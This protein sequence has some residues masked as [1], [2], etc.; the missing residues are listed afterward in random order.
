[1]PPPERDT[2]EREPGAEARQ[3]SQVLR[4]EANGQF[5]RAAAAWSQIQRA[6]LNSDRWAGEDWRDPPQ[7]EGLDDRLAAL[8]AWRGPRDTVA[9]RTYLRARDLVNADQGAKARR[10]LSRLIREPFRARADYLRASLRF[11]EDPLAGAVAFRAFLQR[12]PRDPLGLYMLG[13]CFFTAIRTDES[14]PQA[15]P[16]ASALGSRAIRPVSGVKTAKPR[17]LPSGLRDRYLRQARTAYEACAALDPHGPLAEDSRGKAAGC[18]FRQGNPVEALVRYCAQLASLPPE[19]ENHYAFL[20]ARQCLKRM[21]LADHRVFQARTLARPEVASIYLDLHLDYGRS[22]ARA[23]YNL[24][25]FALTVLRRRPAAP[26]SGRLLA[27]LALIEDRL[28]RWQSGERLASAAI[29]RCGPGVYRDQAAWQLALSL[30]HLGRPRDALAQYEHLAAVA[31]AANLRR[32]AHEAAAILSEEKGDL[33]N[34]IRHYF[35]LEYGADYGYLVDCVASLDELR[36]FLRRFPQHPRAKLVRYSI[37]FRQL[38][39]AQYDAAVRTFASLGPWLETAE[40]VYDCR[41]VKGK[42]RWPPLRLARFLAGS[43][44]S[45]AAAKR[46]PQKARI[47]YCRGQVLFQQRYLAFYNGVLWRGGREY[48]LDIEGPNS[49]YSDL[50]SNDKNG[51]MAP[52][53]PDQQRVFDRYEAEHTPLYQAAQIFEKIARVYPRTPEAPKALYSAAVCYTLPSH[54]DRFLAAQGIDTTSRAIALYRRLQREYPHD[55]LADAAARYG[56]PLP[57]PAVRKRTAARRR[58]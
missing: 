47:A 23:D 48:T 1:M 18:L 44:R 30:R 35:D 6:R 43:V 12:H 25:Q 24:G 34:A 53:N 5:R 10:L 13:R 15:S 28:G 31:V 57:S 16:P 3:I 20:S 52:L 41:T 45:E 40:K 32:G 14:I 21:T 4:W 38:R 29:A 39:A 49:K 46:V 51:G 2:D 37:G 17:R 54:M 33:P 27:R 58:G 7:V 42:R 19:G 55:R 8:R 56:G 9:L 22:G 26:L 11:Y 36:A 50:F